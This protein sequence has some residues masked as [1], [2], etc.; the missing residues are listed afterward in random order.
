M[1]THESD[2]TFVATFEL[3]VDSLSSQEL[4]IVA[5]VLAELLGDAKALL[6]QGKE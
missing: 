5:T 6:K 2:P 4:E 3:D 1:N